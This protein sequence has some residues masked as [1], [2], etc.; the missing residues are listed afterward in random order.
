MEVTRG[1]VAQHALIFASTS[2]R[3]F[4]RLHYTVADDALALPRESR[5]REVAGSRRC[6]VGAARR[7]D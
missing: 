2:A 3:F 5:S 1:G 6:G 4:E 7:A